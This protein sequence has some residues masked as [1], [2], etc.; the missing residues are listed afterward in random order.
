MAATPMPTGAKATA[1][2]AFAVVGFVVANAYIPLMPDAGADRNYREIS[3]AIGAIIGWQV[4]GP[5]VGKGYVDAAA[6]GIKTVIVLVFYALLA[7]G[8][9]EMLQESVK[10]RYE[11]PLEAIVDIFARMLDRAPPLASMSVLIPMVLGGIIGGVLAENASR[12]W[13]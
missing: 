8:I 9:Y 12:R 11:G 13:T 5:A 1:A 4:M 6:N 2:L 3:A 10:M 7:L